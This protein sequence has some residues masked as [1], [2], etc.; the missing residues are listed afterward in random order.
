MKEE[1][2]DELFDTAIDNAFDLQ[3]DEVDAL[4]FTATDYDNEA[5]VLTEAIFEVTGTVKMPVVIATANPETVSKVLYN[6]S[7]IMGVKV[8]SEDEN[9][10]N[11][12]KDILKA[13]GAPM[14]SI[15]NKIVCC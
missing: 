9:L 8:L 7:G 4:L 12:I 1:L 6:Y 5:D 2:E 14:V 3:D 10:I 15:D 11:S 13:Y